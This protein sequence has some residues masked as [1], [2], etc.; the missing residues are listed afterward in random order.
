MLE[1]HR[2]YVKCFF[3]M[4]EWALMIKAWASSFQLDLNTLIWRLCC[5]Y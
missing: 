5:Y 1:V 4:D 3:Y 2:V